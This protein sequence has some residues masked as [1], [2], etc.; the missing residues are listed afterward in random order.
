MSKVKGSKLKE[1]DIPTAADLNEIY[2]QVSGMDIDDTNTTDNWAHQHHFE[3]APKRI[4]EIYSLTY[5][6]GSWNTSSTTFLPV[7]SQTLSCPVT[8]DASDWVLRVSWDALTGGLEVGVDEDLD[9]LYGFRIKVGFSSGLTKYIA[10]AVYSFTCRSLKTAYPNLTL[11]AI[12]WKSCAGS[13]AFAVP[14]G[15]SLSYIELEAAVSNTSN[16]LNVDRI[17]ITAVLGRK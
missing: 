15:E 4:N 17:N 2:T 1:G 6:T 14:R 11:D 8:A 9:G 10:P 5:T 3:N 12:Q 16:A 13:E 7:F